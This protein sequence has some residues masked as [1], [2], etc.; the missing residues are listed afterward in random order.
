[1]KRYSYMLTV[2]FLCFGMGA[3]AANVITISSVEGAPD[4]EVTVSIGLQNTD[5]LSSLQVSIPLDENL[6]LVSGSAQA[7]SRCSG[8]AASVGVNDGALQVVLYS[9]SMATID[10]GSGEVVSFKLKLGNEPF[11]AAL[12][13]AKM[14]LTDGNGS[15]VDASC[16]SGT[17]TIRCA[18]AQFNTDEIDFGRVPILSSYTRDVL[19]T[20]VGNADLTVSRMEFSDVNVFSSTTTL[21]LT[22]APGLS[23]WLNVTFAPT[24][25]GTVERQLRIVN[26]AGKT[27][28]LRLKAQPYTVNELHIDD[29]SGISD[30]ELTITMRMN[31]MDDISGYQVDF[32][33][34]SSLQ[35]V[36]GS[37]VV[38][39][40]RKQDHVG[41]ASVVDG[42]LH[43]VAYSPSGKP[44][45]GNDGVIGT[46][47]V[48][49]VGVNSEYLTPVKTVLTATI[50]NT[51]EN[52]V[53]DVCG[54]WVTVQY[55]RIYSEFNI[56]FGAVPVTE[57]CQ[58]TTYIQN[59]GS[60]P[61]TVSRIVFNN[62]HLSVAEEM[63]LVIPN[64]TSRDVTVTYSS[65]EETDFESIMQIYSNDPASRIR[66]VVVTGSRFAPN[67]MGLST[68]DV[69]V[70]GELEVKLS[71]D[72]YNDMTGL[73]FDMEYPNDQY[74][75]YD[76]NVLT[77]LRAAGMTVSSSQI[78]T[79]TIRYVAY[80]LNG[81]SIAA[82][83][84]DILS[85]RLKP[86]AE[87]TPE[88]T[89]TVKIKNIKLG[90]AA[91]VD[92]YAGSNLE[93]SF[94]IKQRMVTNLV[95]DLA[96]GWN[97]IST[98]VT[99]DIH[100]FLE[101]V[102]DKTSRL[103]SQTQEL[104]NDAEFGLVGS[105]QTM[106]VTAGYK[107]KM[108]TESTA[109]LTG[110]F[111]DPD[112]TLLQLNKG[113]NW[114][115]YVPMV[116]LPVQTAL[117]NLQATAGD[118]IVHQDGFAEYDGTAW[119]PADMIMKPGQGYMYMSARDLAFKYS[120]AT[121]ATDASRMR[122]RDDD[123]PESPWHYD[124]HRY[125]DVTTIIASITP[126]LGSQAETNCCEGLPL[127]VGAFCGEEC[128]GVGKVVSDLLFITVHG[129][130][131]EGETVTFRAYDPASGKYYLADDEIVFQGQCLGAV[132]SPMP[133]HI[134]NTTTGIA[135]DRLS[136]PVMQ[137]PEAVYDLQ[138]RKLSTIHYPLSTI[139]RPLLIR[140]KN[141]CQKHLK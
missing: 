5:A 132:A 44:L 134:R 49:I 13:P 121:S 35:F 54:G 98:N 99:T 50:N 130:I 34:P 9:L 133:L 77:E 76:G 31:N 18:K 60:V 113:W 52:V 11:I 26:S 120:S 129:T 33:L 108:E 37:F 23:A 59:I 141:N 20:N 14:V 107:L 4:E 3:R 105:L 138:G 103:L 48:K 38:D 125:P 12:Q 32:V 104:I 93:S 61:L 6:T 42:T 86:V 63:P 122:L 117:E 45:K 47:R 71:L 91:L 118:R 40:N 111:A 85:I 74:E 58:R 82:G 8:H 106:E 83:V 10:P 24:E 19:L 90:T 101:P 57:E 80:F 109:Y 17:V 95:I 137:H 131:A 75:P 65:L 79:N 136:S 27:R 70:D 73:Q 64:G 89:Y 16:E 29:A 94:Q 119:L 15:A 135:D 41:A 110:N 30:E 139:H 69:Y 126:P 1:M 62:E 2:L 28:T 112:A 43:I 56:D 72:T 114:I 84:G 46:F 78:S 67:Y 102:K 22:V 66:E 96:Q 25:R 124:A 100:S 53:S 116:A 92:K 97:W 55:P 127:Q 36:D 128:R 7:G 51:V 68:P 123:Q 81:G 21:P 140:D 87:I 88:G 39:S 115:G